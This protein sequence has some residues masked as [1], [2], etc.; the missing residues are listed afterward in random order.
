MLQQLKNELEN[1][2]V[3]AE[4]V[5]NIQEMNDD[6]DESL[7][8]LLRKLASASVEDI[9]AAN[10]G[11]GNNHTAPLLVEEDEVKE[12]KEQIFDDAAADMQIRESILVMFFS[13]HCIA[14]GKACKRSGTCYRCL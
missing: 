8:S 13:S 2:N 14:S 4:N 9:K 7:E 1:Q 11:T 3:A 5:A 10:F 12:D 6:S